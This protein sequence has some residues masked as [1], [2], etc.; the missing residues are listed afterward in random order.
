M[1]RWNGLELQTLEPSELTVNWL[2]S[3]DADH[4]AAAGLYF[5]TIYGPTGAVDATTV[6]QR[7]L[8]GD[9]SGCGAEYEME[10][11]LRPLASASA[12]AGQDVVSWARASGDAFIHASRCLPGAGTSS[13]AASCGRRLVR[14]T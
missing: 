1:W 9:A 2:W 6:A 13:P 8:Y 12:G 5:T 11:E 7:T 3:L 14:G 10:L 4:V